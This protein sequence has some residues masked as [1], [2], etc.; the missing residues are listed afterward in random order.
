MPVKNCPLN[1]NTDKKE[2]ANRGTP[3]FPCGGYFSSVGN[4]ITQAIPWHWHEEIEVLVVCKG[5][6]K[7]KL[8]GQSYLINTG[9][10]AFINSGVLHSAVKNGEENCTIKSFVLHSSIIS[11]MIE[12]VFAQ[13]YVNPLLHCSKLQGIHFNI[14]TDWHMEVVGYILDAFQLHQLE[15]FGF[16]L[17]IRDKLSQVW[18]FII[19]NYQ[20][21][22]REQ[23]TS[24]QLDSLRLKE[25]LTYI[26]TN[27]ANQIKLHHIAEAATISERECLRCFKRV[28][29]ITP[30]KYLMRHRISVAAGFLE[31]SSMNIAE[32]SGSTGFDSPSYFSLEFKKIVEMTPREYRRKH[33]I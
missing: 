33:K 2:I 30:M 5:K 20:E 13:R 18:F 7:L 10:G 25:M 27:Y 6:L 3:M 15:P 24:H 11:G 14:Y 31:N 16:E 9:E 32:I 29:G 1:I 12:S 17:L 21:I 8:P 19:S 4:H 22:L 23:Q 28:L 26:H